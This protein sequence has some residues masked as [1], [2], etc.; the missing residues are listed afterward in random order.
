ML[1]RHIPIHIEK[2]EKYKKKKTHTQK[3]AELI[4]VLK[5]EHNLLYLVMKANFLPF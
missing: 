4:H 5:T 2:E 3:T 1:T